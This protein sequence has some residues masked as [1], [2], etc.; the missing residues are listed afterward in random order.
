M[1]GITDLTT[2]IVGTVLIVLLPGPN[3]LFVLA[4]SARHG[5]RSGYAAALGI[6]LGDLILMIA[7]AGG[8]ASLLAASPWLFHAVKWLGAAYLAWLGLGLLGQAWRRWQEPATDA[9]Q[10][11]ATNDAEAIRREDLAHPFRH[12]LAISLVNPKAILFFIAFFIQFVDPAYPYPAL[13]FALLGL[14]VEV[15]SLAYLSALIFGGVH[16]AHAVSR[17]RWL[18]AGGTASV[19]ALFLGFSAKLAGSTL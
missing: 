15:F 18:A 2:F 12:A 4:T 6:A 10:A 13:S 3:S 16:L 14:I 5:V 17:R 9:G 7:A 1:F 8:V 11:T 19:G